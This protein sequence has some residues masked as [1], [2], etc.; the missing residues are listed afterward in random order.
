MRTFGDL[1]FDEFVDMYSALSPKA[2][3]ETKIQTAF[4]MYDS[5]GDGYLDPEDLAR[6]LQVCRQREVVSMRN[7]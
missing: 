6:L 4:R 2:K 1:S 7:T 5:N 3:K